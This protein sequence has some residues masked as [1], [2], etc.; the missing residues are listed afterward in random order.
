MAPLG[1]ITVTG[2]SEAS[3]TFNIYPFDQAFNQ[4]G[5]VYLVTHQYKKADG[6]IWHDFLYIGQTGSLPERFSGHHKLTCFQRNSANCICVHRDD[7]ERSRLANEAD[8]LRS[9]TLPCND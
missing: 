1:T 5:A 2:A 9:R 3:Y 6:T 4:V 8:L 7:S